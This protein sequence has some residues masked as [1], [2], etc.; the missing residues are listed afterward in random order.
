MD[1]ESP[2]FTNTQYKHVSHYDEYSHEHRLTNNHTIMRLRSVCPSLSDKNTRRVENGK[3]NMGCGSVMG[4]SWAFGWGVR[5][6][7]KLAFRLGAHAALG[8]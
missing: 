3:G 7:Q 6:T 8:F 5:E 4:L 1:D 2:T